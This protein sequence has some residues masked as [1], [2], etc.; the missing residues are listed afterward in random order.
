M[1]RSGIGLVILL[2][3]CNDLIRVHGYFFIEEYC[4]HIMSIDYP[5]TNHGHCITCTH[6]YLAALLAPISSKSNN[7]VLWSMN[8]SL[9]KMHYHDN[10]S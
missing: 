2:A 1:N 6:N 10:S 9:H 8:T 5:E 3:L 7:C 4:C